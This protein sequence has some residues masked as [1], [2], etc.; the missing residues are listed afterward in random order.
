MPDL[1]NFLKKHKTDL[2]TEVIAALTT[3]FTMAYILVVNPLILSDAGMPFGA[4][5]TATALAAGI[6]SIIMGLRANR[7]LAIATGMGLNAFFAYTVVVGMGFTWQIAMAASFIASA[8]LF[9]IA[10]AGINISH[11]M[12]KSFKFGLIA[13]L[14]LFLVLIGMRNAHFVVMNEAT[15]VGIG[16]F[17]NP[18]TLIGALGFFIVSI[19]VVRKVSGA[20]FIG[21]F[22]T[23]LLAMATGLAPLPEGIFSL[24]PSPS[25]L[26][27]QLDFEGILQNLSIL[28]VVWTFFIILLFDLIGT[29][30]AM[31][32]Q[33]G[34]ADKK[35][36]VS[37]FK[38]ALESN[39]LAGMFGAI[40][41]APALV[42]YLENATGIKAGGK[43]GL[44]AIGVGILFFISLFFFPL[45]RAIP[46]EAAAPAIV[47]VGLFMLSTVENIEFHDE[48]ESIPALITLGTIPFTFSISHGIAVGSVIY[49]TLKLFTGKYKEIHPAMYLIAILS[50]LD[51]AHVF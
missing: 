16:D 43:T 6:G 49:V 11:A 31:L 2:N 3:F 51:F 23:T 33:A 9:L 44:V 36:K 8:L 26:F 19:L 24:P 20:L 7:P 28:P 32:T 1:K 18:A 46:I 40:I 13:G 4:I 41:G 15:L 5:F 12:P 21:V 30:I 42:T 47:L 38:E 48:T 50:L 35:G 29:N 45:I 10:F 37:G 14:G 27:F 22:A 39:G 25:P 34:Y 17:S